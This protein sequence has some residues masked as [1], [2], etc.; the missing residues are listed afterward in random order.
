[1]IVATLI[2]QTKTNAA[3]EGV[4]QIHAP[5]C[6]HSNRVPGHLLTHVEDDSKWLDYGTGLDAAVAYMIDLRS[7]MLD[8][9]VVN[10]PWI[11]RPAPCAKA[12]GI[13]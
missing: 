4:I 12:A 2:E 8:D 3:G 10:F 13:A 11:S 1:M 5:G 7:G 9:G 6:A